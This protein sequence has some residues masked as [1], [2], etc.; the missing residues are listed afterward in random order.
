MAPILTELFRDADLAPTWDHGV[1]LISY[2]SAVRVLSGPTVEQQ[3]FCEL[4]WRAGVTKGMATR[5]A[6]VGEASED[7]RWYRNDSVTRSRNTAIR[8]S[9]RSS[10]QDDFAKRPILNQM[11]QGFARLAEAIHPLDDRLD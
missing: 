2:E 6:L 10:L 11:T 5:P 8:L 9:C 1:Y 3:E 4:H 7:W